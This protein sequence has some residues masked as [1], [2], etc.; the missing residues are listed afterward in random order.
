M[1]EDQFQVVCKHQM[2]PEPPE[3]PP[4]LYGNGNNPSENW[5]ES[6]IHNLREQ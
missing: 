4:L 6:L 1:I 3:A 2:H 5:E